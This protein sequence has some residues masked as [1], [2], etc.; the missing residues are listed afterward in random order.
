MKQSARFLADV[1]AFLKASE[2]S[3]TAFGVE[4]LK[5]PN[6]VTDLRKGRRPTLGVVDKV[7]DFMRL[8][9]LER[10]W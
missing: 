9:E 6:F 3:D 5:D 7:Y 1:E 8:K 2:M 10:L 4:A